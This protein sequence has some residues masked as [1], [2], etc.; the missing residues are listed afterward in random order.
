MISQLH[1]ISFLYF[2]SLHLFEQKVLLKLKTT[3]NKQKK[4][5]KNNEKRNNSAFLALV[6]DK[7]GKIQKKIQK[8]KLTI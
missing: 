6:P 1:L 3:Q 4:T 2:H 5:T 7:N 8:R